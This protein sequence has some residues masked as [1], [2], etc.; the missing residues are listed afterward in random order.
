[1]NNQSVKAL[2]IKGQFIWHHHDLEDEM[3]FVIKGLLKIE[4]HSKIEIINE[5]E[6]IIVP[7]GVD[8]RCIADN[9]VHLLLF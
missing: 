2:K 5:S 1:L 9:E 8:H 3:F 6:F 7:K 4:F